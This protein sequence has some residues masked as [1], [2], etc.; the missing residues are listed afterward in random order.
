MSKWKYAELLAAESKVM[1]YCTAPE[2]IEPLIARLTRRF[3]SA[4]VTPHQLFDRDRVYCWNLSKLEYLGSNVCF[5]LFSELCDQ[6]WEPFGA[7]A[8]GWDTGTANVGHYQLR[9]LEA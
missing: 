4:I 7:Q 6:G 3:P 1:I 9:L 8:S 5:W 2:V